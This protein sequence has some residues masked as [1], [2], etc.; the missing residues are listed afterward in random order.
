MKIWYLVAGTAAAL[1]IAV[2]ARQVLKQLDETEG[3]L[4]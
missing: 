3:E 2:I 1:A 4:Q